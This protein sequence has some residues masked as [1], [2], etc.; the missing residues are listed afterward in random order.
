MRIGYRFLLLYL[1]VA[2]AALARLKDDLNRAR[3]L[4]DSAGRL[5]QESGS[6]YE[7]GLYQLE[8]GRL[9][10]VEENTPEAITHLKGA[11]HCFDDGGQRVESARAH[12]YL[13][14][15]C[16]ATGDKKTAMVHLE[17]AFHQA[18]TLGS[19]HTLVVAGREATALLKTVQDDPTVGHRAS[20]LLQQIVQFGHD[21]PTLRRRLRRQAPTIPFAPPRLT[22]QT[23]GK[24]QAELDG[25][26]VTDPEWQSRKIVRDLF[27]LL[28]AHPDGLSKEKVG[29]IFWP[30]SSPAQLKLRFK[31]AIYRLRRALGQEI[32]LFDE[33]VY[34]FNRTLDYEYDV[35]AFW[36]KLA[37]AQA[38]TSPDERAAAYREAIDLYVG[39]YLPEMEGT[40]VWP[41][42]ERLWQAYVEAILRLAEFYLET[43]EY[44][45]TLEYCRHALVKD[46]SL[47]AVHC[48]AMRAHAAMGN[49]AAVARQ[50][51]RCQQILLEE[52]NV[53]PSLQTEALYETLM[54]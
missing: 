6:G 10:L 16:Q 47:E 26:P 24:T 49:R 54:R 30:D 36:E 31:N 28:L 14:A 44:E 51:E 13:A 27:F 50:F 39:P 21:I 23:L 3:N 5:A 45:M 35:E 4:L 29:T 19:Q 46:P 22:I 32:V 17:R 40:W 15:A 48:L 8:I 11:A 41:E 9:A 43:G 33:D 34:Q 37:Q 52:I 20:Q 25:R 12:L 7:R 53:P 18:S 1:D 2:E 38:A 42:R